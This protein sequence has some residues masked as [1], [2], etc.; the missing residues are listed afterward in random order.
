MNQGKV[1]L[2][3]TSNKEIKEAAVFIASLI[4]NSTVVFET[5]MQYLTHS[6][7]LIVK[8]SGAN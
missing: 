4:E 7:N 3:Y 6:N 1:T 2:P 5:E 8:F